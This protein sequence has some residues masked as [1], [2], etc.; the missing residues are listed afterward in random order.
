MRKIVGIIGGGHYKE[1]DAEYKF[2][3]ELAHNLVSA[4]YRIVTG[5]KG[6]VM[7]A[8]SMGAMNSNGYFEGSV[9]CILKESSKDSANDFCDVVIPTG[10]GISRNIILVNTADIFVAI[11]GGAGT[12][13]EI[14]F[15]W[16]R[17]KTVLCVTKFDGWAKNL[18]GQKLD[19]RHNDLLIPVKSI[20]EIIEILTK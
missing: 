7:E 17:G 20:D 10:I 3:V 9:I 1:S 18:A 16:Q 19:E 2:A 4:G 12:M 15:A 5:G 6:G 14:A 13:S 11:G 8:A